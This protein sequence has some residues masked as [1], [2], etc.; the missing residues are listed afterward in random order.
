MDYLLKHALK[1]MLQGIPFGGGT[2]AINALGLSGYALGG[3]AGPHFGGV[4]F[5]AFGE[6]N[7]DEVVL[8]ATQMVQVGQNLSGG[9]GGGNGMV[10]V[11]TY[12]YLDKDKIAT[13]VSK[14]MA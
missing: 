3:L 1:M 8:N 11:T 7:Q 5:G 10:Q 13:A 6:G 14:H 2:A 12:I 9:G 4:K